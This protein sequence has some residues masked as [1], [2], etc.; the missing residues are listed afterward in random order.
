MIVTR[1]VAPARLERN[2]LLVEAEL[3]APRRR[4]PERLLVRVGMPVDVARLMG[5]T[6]A[7]RRSWIIAVTVALLFGLSAAD[8]DRPG[9]SVLLF[10]A[11]APLV[12][13]AGVALAYG[14]GVDP[15]YE[16]TITTPIDGF[17]LLLVRSAAVLL[18]SV[19]LAGSA[20]LLLAGESPLVAAW[21]VPA[22][23]LT[24]VCL[25]LSSWLAPRVAGGVVAGIWLA[26]VVAAARP[27]DDDLALFRAGGQL[28]LAVVGAVAVAV[29]V[30][31]RGAFD[32]G[33]GAGTP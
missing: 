17:R 10:L 14:R 8:P 31:R 23:S 19:G 5:A 9:S 15:A 13:V 24:A 25:A 29:L 16:V 4:L 18:A 32:T 21:L 6:P 2:F 11:L 27:A 33:R 26:L 20:S 28:A 1:A 3:D 30:A 7:L 12:P 22:L